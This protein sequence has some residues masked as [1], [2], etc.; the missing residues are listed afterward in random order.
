MVTRLAPERRNRTPE[1][2]RPRSMLDLLDTFWREPFEATPFSMPEFPS[3]NISEDDK[4]ITVEAEVPGM[5]PED[6]DIS[7]HNNNLI[8]QGEKKFEDEEN[9]DSYHRIERSYGSFYR[10]I[11][12]PTEVDDNNVKANYKNG[13]L[14]ITLPKSEQSRSKKIHIES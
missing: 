12:L 3:V 2:R 4:Y 6:L 14:N 13:I 10:T 11:P 1:T 5:K 9:R 8:I 7:M